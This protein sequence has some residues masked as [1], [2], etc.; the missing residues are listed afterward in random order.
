[1]SVNRN[2]LFKKGARNG[3]LTVRDAAKFLDTTIPMIRRNK[4][5]LNFLGCYTKVKF[6][7]KLVNYKNKFDKR[8]KFN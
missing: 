5:K 1:M 4:N 2:W 7:S 8:R 3:F 6:D